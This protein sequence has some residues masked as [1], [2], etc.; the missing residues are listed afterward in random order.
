MLVFQFSKVSGLFE[1]KGTSAPVADRRGYFRPPVDITFLDGTF[2]IKMDLP[3]AVPDDLTI[4]AGDFEVS[5]FGTIHL[6][7]SQGPCRLMER[8]TGDF[9]RTLAFPIRIAPDKVTASMS[10]GVLEIAVPSVDLDRDPT[11]IEI[12]LTDAD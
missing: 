2:I 1:I 4:H 12:K 3:G 7:D 8:P 6:P 5:I 9:L 11:R 10:N